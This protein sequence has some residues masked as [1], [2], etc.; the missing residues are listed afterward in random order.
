MFF[1]AARPRNSRGVDHN[2]KIAM[3]YNVADGLQ[4]NSDDSRLGFHYER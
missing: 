2:V 1:L 4:C 3:D